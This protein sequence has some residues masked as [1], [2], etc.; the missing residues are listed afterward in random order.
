MSVDLPP[1]FKPNPGHLPDDAHGK[2]VRVILRHG[3][4]PRYG[5][6]SGWAADGRGACSWSLRRGD[7]SIV[8]YMVL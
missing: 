1:G 5:E 4:E 3:R 7:F 8:G 2:R 6:P